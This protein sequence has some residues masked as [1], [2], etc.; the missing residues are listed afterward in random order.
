MGFLCGRGN[1][2][3]EKN[4]HFAIKDLVLSPRSATRSVVM[5]QMNKSLDFGLLNWVC[6]LYHPLPTLAHLNN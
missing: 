2:G 4:A 1:I 5:F 3:D 6:L